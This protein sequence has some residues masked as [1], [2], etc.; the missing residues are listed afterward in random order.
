MI[1]ILVGGQCLVYGLTHIKAV[2]CEGGDLVLHWS[3]TGDARIP[4]TGLTPE[5]AL[6]RWRDA[7][8]QAH[9]TG[10][11]ICDLESGVSK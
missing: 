2:G 6:S 8:R 5:K 1:E 9:A 4:H 7:C 3:E 11:G 10:W